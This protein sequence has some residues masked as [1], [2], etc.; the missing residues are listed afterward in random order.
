MTRPYR[1]LMAVLSV[2]LGF[3]PVIRSRMDHY[4]SRSRIADRLA[5]YVS[6]QHALD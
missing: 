5:R 3:D 6:S 4:V 1:L 2:L